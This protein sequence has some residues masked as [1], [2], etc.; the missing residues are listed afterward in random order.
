LKRRFVNS[1]CLLAAVATALSVALI[2]KASTLG[3]THDEG[4]TYLNFVDYGS[5]L[6]A[7]SSPGG[8]ANNHLL[9]TLLMRL[10][11]QF[12]QTELF[13]RLPNVLAGIF[14]FGWSA[15]WATRV[16]SSTPLRL[17]VFAALT[18]HPYL[19]DFFAVGRGYGLSMA[20]LLASLSYFAAW[21][22]SGRPRYW[23]VALA[24]GAL[25]F[26]AH[27][28][29]LHYLLALIAAG[30]LFWQSHGDLR[31]E[32]P[33]FWR[34]NR[35]VA[36]TAL[37]LAVVAGVPFVRVLRG[38]DLGFGGTTGFRAD[39]WQ[40]LYTRM[41]YDKKWMLPPLDLRLFVEITLLSILAVSTFVALRYVWQRSL[42]GRVQAGIWAIT[43]LCFALPVAQFYLRG[44]P[45]LLDRTALLY[46]PL[47][48]MLTGRLLVQA[49]RRQRPQHWLTASS[50][51]L[52]AVLLSHFI[53]SFS[54][55]RCAEWWFDRDSK[56]VLRAV[57]AAQPG[58][59]I[60]F[61]AHRLYHPSCGY[62][63]ASKQFPRIEPIPWQAAVDTSGV[64]AFYY[65]PVEE[66]A[67]LE[68]KYEV[69]GKFVEG[70][71]MRRKA[72][73]AGVPASTR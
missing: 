67:K 25:A 42:P 64:F 21:L 46:F 18:L 1:S 47:L 57:E 63:V 5:L 38:T 60:R 66:R 59:T 12:G 50:L 49:E 53:A 29:L 33:G 6:H 44:L 22:E 52:T 41:I 69:A 28:V 62:Y 55:D 10:T 14:Y 61:G 37:G 72:D 4:S 58:G 71:L 45:M 73:M 40:S 70:W 7:W 9:N 48:G 2:L 27:Y 20:F 23:Q 32:T 56:A 34:L 8:S 16:T 43:A 26:T 30:N 15:Y 13:V 51:V 35:P 54:L 36:L 17:A 24:A 19:F 3:M 31:R 11:T 39:T 68:G 65:V